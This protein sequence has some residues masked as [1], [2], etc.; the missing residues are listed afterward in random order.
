M[1]E[2]DVNPGTVPLG[3]FLILTSLTGHLLPSGVPSGML[4]ELFVL[5]TQNGKLTT[6]LSAADGCQFL[7]A[8]SD[9]TRLYLEQACADGT[10]TLPIR[11]L[12]HNALLYG[13]P[14]PVVRLME[15]AFTATGTQLW[16][17]SRR[18]PHPMAASGNAIASRI[19]GTV[20]LRA[21][22]S[23]DPK[24]LDIHGWR[25]V[26][27]GVDPTTGRLLSAVKDGDDWLGT[28]RADGARVRFPATSD[29]HPLWTVRLPGAAL[30]VA[31]VPTDPSLPLFVAVDASVPSGVARIRLVA[32]DPMTG[33]VRDTSEP[34][35]VAT[36][37]PCPEHGACLLPAP[38][39]AEPLWTAGDAAVMYV[40]APEGA[41][42][43]CPGPRADD[44]RSPSS[45]R[46][47]PAC[48][49]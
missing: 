47:S 23:D 13:Q 42:R 6:T 39:S 27:S 46:C 29:T 14:A 15:S 44:Q 34:V 3:R 45:A 37:A 1:P 22:L 31:P 8:T 4:T 43:S 10:E 33:Q 41:G 11:N 38:D 48:Q 5:D 19:P 21:L 24:G 2:P 20:M 25:S 7:S 36:H 18:L 28:L 26:S 17:L 9:A 12:G 30:W 35:E 32:L 16:S 49:A 40:A